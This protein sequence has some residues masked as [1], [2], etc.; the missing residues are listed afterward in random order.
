MARTKLTVWN[1]MEEFD[2]LAARYKETRRDRRK[3]NDP[4]YRG[5]ERRLG[6]QR[7]KEIW[8]IIKYLEKEI[9]GDW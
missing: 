8:K 6:K 4:F 1:L 5:H 9:N 2:P 3:V 7:E